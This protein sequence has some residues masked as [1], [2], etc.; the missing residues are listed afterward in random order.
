MGHGMEDFIVVESRKVHGYSLGLYAIFDGHSGRDVAKYLQS[1]LIE[2]ILS[3]S[4]FWTHPKSAVRRAYEATD[5][6][7]L[8]NVVGSQ[9][10]LTAVTAILIDGKKLVVANVG[11]S[12]AILCRNGKDEGITVVHEPLKEKKQVEDR[13]GC[14]VKLPGNI[15]RVD[16]QLEMTRAFGDKKVKKHITAKPDVVGKK[17]DKDVGLPDTGKRLVIAS[18]NITDVQE[19]AEELIKEALVRESRDDTSCVVVMFD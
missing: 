19:A 15:P 5:T 1:N 4:D 13:G 6:D 8:E 3:Q 12:R 2:N 10:G 14:V 18:I 17:I 7:I 11:D 16:G 9:G